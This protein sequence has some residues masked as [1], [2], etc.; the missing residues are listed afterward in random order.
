MARNDSNMSQINEATADDD[1]SEK[2]SD[3]DEE[4]GD[5]DEVGGHEV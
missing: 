4:V 1:A 5:K 3:S 2:F